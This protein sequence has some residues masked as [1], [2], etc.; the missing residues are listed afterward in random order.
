MTPNQ[1][2]VTRC[3]IVS[4]FVMLSTSF[5]KSTDAWLLKLVTCSCIFLGKQTGWFPRLDVKSDLFWKHWE[6]LLSKQ[7]AVT[8]QGSEPS[9]CLREVQPS[10][11]L[12]PHSPHPN[13]VG[14]QN[15]ERHPMSAHRVSQLM[16]R[17]WKPLVRTLHSTGGEHGNLTGDWLSLDSSKFTKVLLD[18]ARANSVYLFPVLHSKISCWQPEIG[19]GGS[20]Y[21]MEPGKCY[22]SEWFLPQRTGLP[23]T[24]NMILWKLLS[25]LIRNPIIFPYL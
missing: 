14:E 16:E 10:I 25:K 12:S 19:H 11:L 4:C 1:H 21:T 18:L 15:N 7:C 2:F 22:K 5:P 24:S 9:L 3:F 23:A 6:T 20:I 17:M 8:A 13:R